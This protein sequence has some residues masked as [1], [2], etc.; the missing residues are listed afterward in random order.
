MVRSSKP[1]FM[2]ER[3]LNLHLAPEKVLKK[4]RRHVFYSETSCLSFTH[5]SLQISVAVGK[6]LPHCNTAQATLR[7]TSS[8]PERNSSTN[9]E[10]PPSARNY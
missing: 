1:R 6:S 9:R 7:R 10:R 8:L 3:R 5:P 2:T 4:R